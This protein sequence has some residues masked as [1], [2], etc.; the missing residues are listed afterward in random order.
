MKK[1]LLGTSALAAL[2]LV[3]GNAQAQDLTISGSVETIIGVSDE[4]APAAGSI[5]YEIL[6]SWDFTFTWTNV[7]DNGLRYGGVLDVDDTGTNGL[8]IDEAFVFLEGDWGRIQMGNKEGPQ[9]DLLVSYPTVGDGG[10]GGDFGAFV[11]GATPAN[12]GSFWTGAF[13]DDSR[14]SYLNL[15]RA[16]D[17]LDFGVAY[18]PETSSALTTNQAGVNTTGAGVGGTFGQYTDEFGG[19]AN[20]TFDFEGGSVIVSGVLLTSDAPDPYQDPFEYAFG[21]RG[22]FG[23]FSIGGYYLNGGDGGEPAVNTNSNDAERWG[24]G[25]TYSIDGWGVGVNYRAFSDQRIGVV[26]A[27]PITG[28]PDEDSGYA[29][30]GDVAYALAPGLN[31]Y[32]SVVY[33]DVDNG[34]VSGPAAGTTAVVNGSSNWAAGPRAAGQ[35]EGV[36]GLL[37]MTA[38]F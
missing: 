29:I 25:A 21:A 12:S 35:N 24:A 33:F 14:L 4:D 23:G 20:Y 30:G 22:T 38:S 3:A 27:N 26:G 28:Q 13:S 37:G 16:V 18:A 15:G 6:S 2:A 36:V 32:G 5:S 11:T 17:G 9:E 7:A 31:V 19:G 8:N 34:A 1:V 10:V